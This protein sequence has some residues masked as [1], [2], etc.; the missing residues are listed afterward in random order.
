M[1]SRHVAP[2]WRSDRAI[3]T[4]LY[5]LDR[6]QEAVDELFRAERKTLGSRFAVVL[7][8]PWGAPVLLQ[9]MNSDFLAEAAKSMC[10]FRLGQPDAAKARLVLARQVANQPRPEE[11]A[12]LREAEEL[13]ES[14]KP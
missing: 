6:P 4:L 3:G 13:I 1:R 9:E 11:L 7:G 10:L 14:K 8:S 5:R 2:E 12:F